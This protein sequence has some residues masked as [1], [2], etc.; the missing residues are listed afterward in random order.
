M[1][2]SKWQIFYEVNEMY[3]T[4]FSIN[5]MYWGI[6]WLGVSKFAGKKNIMEGVANRALYL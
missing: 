4:G 2:G 6:I 5:C 3:E 1:Q